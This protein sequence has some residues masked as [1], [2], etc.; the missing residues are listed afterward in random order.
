MSRHIVRGR[1]GSLFVLR[2]GAS[3]LPPEES[4]RPGENA[5]LFESIPEVREAGRVYEE[6]LGKRRRGEQESKP[7]RRGRFT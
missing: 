4:N 5:D 7:R 6:V 2:P 3:P 1:G